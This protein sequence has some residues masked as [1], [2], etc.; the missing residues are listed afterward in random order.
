MVRSSTPRPALLLLAA[1]AGTAGPAV[2]QD[3]GVVRGSVFDSLTMAP[4]SDAAV[5]LW[6]TPYRTATDSLGRFLL[7]HVPPGDYNVLYY[8]ARLGEAGFSSGPLPIHL[9]A[10]QEVAVDLATPSVFTLV[11]SECLLEETEPGTGVVAGWVGD[12]ESGMGLPGANVTLSWNVDDA[13]APERMTLV[14]DGRGWYRTCS[15]PAGVPITASARFLNRTGLRREVSVSEGGVVEAGFLVGRLRPADVAGLLVDATSAEAVAGAEVWLRGTSFRGMSGPDGRFHFD[16]VPPGSYMLMT[17]HLGYGV[18]MDTLR[19]PTGERIHVEMRLDQRAIEMA[20]LTVTV[21]STPLTQRAMG[22]LTIDRATIEEVRARVRDVGDILRS[23]NVPGVIVNRN[24]AGLCI[25]YMT[26]QVRMMFRGDCTPM[27]IFIDNV[28][29]SNEEIAAQI[30]PDAIDRI[31][32]Y[33]PVEAGNLFGLGA[34]NGV[35]AIF[36]RG[37]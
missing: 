1:L 4:L 16:D 25:G 35:M 15:A 27:L 26:G 10:G 22:G 20:P 33:K 12:N 18:K 19:V 3:A 2:A 7:E 24:D 6:D 36:T 8:H 31:V 28:R 34:A 29:V 23:Q 17:D 5:F 14:A 9:E 37:N 11:A 21:E 32:I 13:K 30:S